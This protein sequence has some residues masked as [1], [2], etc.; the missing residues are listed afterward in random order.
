MSGATGNSWRVT[1]RDFL[2]AGAAGGAGLVIGF[3]WAFG[4]AEDAAEASGKDFAPNAYIEIKPGGEIRLWVAR[5][6]M[7]QGPRTSLAMILAEEL[8]A[9][10]AH[11][12]IEQ[13]DLDSKY[14]DQTTG[15]SMSIRS[16]WDPLRQ[17]GATAR[18]MLVMAAASTWKVP[19]GECTTRNSAVLHPKTKRQLGYGA[20]A[21]KAGALPV[22]KNVPLKKPA[23]YQI[24][25]TKKK[26][27]DGE[28]I[29]I[30]EAHY[31]IDTKV[32]GMLYAAV[33]R[34][35]V[36]GGRVKKFDATRAQAVPGVRQV[37]EI[38]A[39][40]MP[41]RA[42]PTASGALSPAPCELAPWA[43]R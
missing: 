40:E 2:K 35:P 38:P 31:G 17:A 7:G 8:D 29:V 20:L 21:A 25:G 15:G 36:F 10:W 9:D 42:A 14:G 32:P 5:S 4:L 34:P 37:I 27:V 28:H 41:Q 33:A 1:R 26:R 43:R 39:V 24:L 23:E 3:R 16:S 18:A 19:E 12:K 6:E 11:V 30:G 13:A 22:P